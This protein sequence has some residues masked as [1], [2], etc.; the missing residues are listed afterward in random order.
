LQNVDVDG[1]VE[2]LCLG[3]LESILSDLLLFW[4]LR[5]NMLGK[6]YYDR[7]DFPTCHASFLILLP[8]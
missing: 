8:Q 7:L 5:W 4:E 2:S 6:H 1:Y 3:K